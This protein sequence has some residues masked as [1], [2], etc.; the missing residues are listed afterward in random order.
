MKVHMQSIQFVAGEH[1]KAFTQ[2]KVE[3]LEQFFDKII[4]AEVFFSLDKKNR[5]IK[6]KVV[7]IKL[8]VPGNQIVATEVSKTFEEATDSASRSLQRQLKKY[9]AKLRS[10]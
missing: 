4:Q 6:D 5:T 8:K 3:K 1:L 10:Q 2:K 7:T 9:K